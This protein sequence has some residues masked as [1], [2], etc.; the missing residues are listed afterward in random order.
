MF[1]RRDFLKT[2]GAGGGA[3]A[4][5]GTSKLAFAACASDPM[6]VCRDIGARFLGDD[7]VLAKEVMPDQLHLSAAAYATWAQ[8]IVADVDTMLR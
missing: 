6:V 4:L 7:G 5:A 2:C 1:D 3:I 8:A